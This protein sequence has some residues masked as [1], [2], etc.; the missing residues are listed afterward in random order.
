MNKDGGGTSN[1]RRHVNKCAGE[2]EVARYPPLDQEKYRENIYEVIINN[3]YPFYFVE[4]E[5]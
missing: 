1:M 5:G 4:H 3:G 2:C